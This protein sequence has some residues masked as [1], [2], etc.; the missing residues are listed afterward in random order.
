VSRCMR[1][2]RL[3]RAATTDA[4]TCILRIR[5]ASSP[6][7]RLNGSASRDRARREIGRSVGQSAGRSVGRSVVC[8]WEGA[9][10]SRLIPAVVCFWEGARASR[11][12]RIPRKWKW[13]RVSAHGGSGRRERE[14]TG[15]VHPLAPQ[16]GARPS[17]GT[18]GA[19]EVHIP[20]PLVECGSAAV[21]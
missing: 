9:R 17:R 1:V 2:G 20:L 6:V 16:G 14:G 4:P 19:V 21:S 15:P 5:C 11:L 10:A 3:G 12:I 7:R 8:F 18:R 13:S